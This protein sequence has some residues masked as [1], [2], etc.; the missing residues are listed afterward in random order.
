V[1]SESGFDKA[2]ISVLQSYLKRKG[3]DIKTEDAKAVLEYI[4]NIL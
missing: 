3:L 2:K 1:F 4:K